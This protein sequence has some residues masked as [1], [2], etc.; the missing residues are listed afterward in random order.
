MHGEAQRAVIGDSWIGVEV[1]YLND[2]EEREENQA[3]HSHRRQSTGLRL[4]VNTD[5]DPLSY[6]PAS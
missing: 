4:A 1:C 3:E 5:S 6:Q 2:N